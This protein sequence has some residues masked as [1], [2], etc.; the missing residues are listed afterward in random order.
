MAAGQHVDRGQY[1]ERVR[2]VCGASGMRYKLG[3]N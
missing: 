2:A 3:H 1:I